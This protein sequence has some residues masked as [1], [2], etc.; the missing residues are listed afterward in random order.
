MS[1]R[2][3]VGTRR[4][5]TGLVSAVV[6]SLVLGG[7]GRGGSEFRYVK[8]ADST[9]FVKVPMKWKSYSNTEL[10]LAEAQLNQSQGTPQSDNDLRADIALNWR[11]GF[12]SSEAPT[13]VDVVVANTDHFVVD[14]RVR[15][16][17]ADE[18]KVINT[19]ALRNLVVPIDQ[20]QAAQDAADKD[21][22]PSLVTNKNFA[23]RVDQEISRPGG[24]HGVQTIVDMRGTDPDT[25]SYV[26]NDV[27]MLNAENTKLYVLNIHCE[28]L[29]YDQHTSSVLQIIHSVT[30]QAKK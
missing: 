29:C 24:F 15:T 7:C 21:Q 5:T 27:V 26:F 14:V 18:R 1:R 22:P 13:P 9:L 25:R 10:V 23:V 11:V 12:D 30:L 28:S 4:W 19:D 3:T 6:L 8:S 16:L 20:L 2:L 17:T